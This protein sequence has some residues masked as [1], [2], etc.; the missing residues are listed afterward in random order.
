MNHNLFA[1]VVFLAIGT[2][3][4]ST[5]AENASSVDA[6]NTTNVVAQAAP[7]PRDVLEA[8]VQNRA[9]TL[10][11][12]YIDVPANHWAYKAVLTMHYCG[13][14]RQGTPPQLIERLLNSTPSPQTPQ[15]E[16]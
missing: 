5:V 13:A 15:S 10:P 4:T 3:A 8:C 9:E 14:Y 7:T 2:F 11:N 16:Q 6:A 12:P 1:A